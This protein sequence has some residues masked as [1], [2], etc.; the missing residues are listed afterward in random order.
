MVGSRWIPMAAVAGWCEMDQDSTARAIV[1]AVRR[2]LAREISFAEYLKLVPEEVADEELAGLL[3]LVEHI[4]KRGGFLGVN[5]ARYRKHEP[6][7][8]DIPCRCV[9]VAR[10]PYEE[11]RAERECRGL[12]RTKEI[13]KVA[14]QSAKH[15]A[16][17]LQ[18]LA[19]HGGDNVCPVHSMRYTASLVGPRELLTARALLRRAEMRAQCRVH[20]GSVLDR[21]RVRSILP[22][23]MLAPERFRQP[24]R[25]FRARPRR[26]DDS[27]L[28]V[29]QGGATE[30]LA[31]KTKPN[32]N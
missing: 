6:R 2:L 26:D 16:S 31:R 4:P 27:V 22:H 18:G 3:S 29:R 24:G 12:P 15:R 21:Q 25:G 9:E 8:A 19:S 30:G 23:P 13:A 17:I 28:K 32:L 20:L 7:N 1:A 11:R 14:L 5:E 10:T